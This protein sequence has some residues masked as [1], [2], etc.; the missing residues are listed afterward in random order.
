MGDRRIYGNNQIQLL[1]NCSCCGK[2]GEMGTQ[3]GNG[4]YGTN[5]IDVFAELQAVTSNIFD[6]K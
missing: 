5:I 6:L 2:I 1:D 4:R 3:I